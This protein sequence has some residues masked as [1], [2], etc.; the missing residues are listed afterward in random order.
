[1]NTKEKGARA[2][3]LARKMLEKVGYI[4]I[5]SARSEGPFDLVAI[6]PHGSTRLIQVKK[7]KPAEKSEREELAELASK[8]KNASVEYWFFPEKSKEPVITV[9]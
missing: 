7:D 4:V 5:R 1:M 3:R 9:F 6:G 8:L 2:E